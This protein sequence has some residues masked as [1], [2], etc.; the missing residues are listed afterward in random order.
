MDGKQI[1]PMLAVVQFDQKRKSKAVREAVKAWVWGKAALWEWSEDLQED[2]WTDLRSGQS[3]VEF[4]Q[5][6]H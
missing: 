5:E 2:I 6:E 4:G 1:S 3:P